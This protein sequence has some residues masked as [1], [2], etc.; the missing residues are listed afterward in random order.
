LPP[1]LGDL[2]L[3]QRDSQTLALAFGPQ[4]LDLGSERR[5]AAATAARGQNSTADDEEVR[6]WQGLGASIAELEAAALG[7][8]GDAEYLAGIASGF[9]SPLSAMRSFRLLTADLKRAALEARDCCI[10]W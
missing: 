5:V 6:P 1:G 4:P 8:L 10:A 9:S 2:E 3:W 7:G